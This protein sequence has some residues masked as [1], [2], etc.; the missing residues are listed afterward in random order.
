VLIICLSVVAAVAVITVV[1]S[2]AVAAAQ[3]VFARRQT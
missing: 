2:E 3:A 1:R